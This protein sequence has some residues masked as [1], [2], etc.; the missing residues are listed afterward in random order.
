M[1]P[2]S[3]LTAARFCLA[4]VALAGCFSLVTEPAEAARSIT[5]PPWFVC[6]KY[7]RTISIS[8]PQIWASYGT[9]QVRWVT[10]I[11]RWDRYS[12]QW[13][14]YDTLSFWSSFNYYGQSVTGWTGGN[15]DGITKNIRVS[16]PG[17]Y[18]VKAAVAGT[19]GPLT[20]VGMISGGAYCTMS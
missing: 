14:D 18:R 19:E 3:I 5:P 4:L 20:W 9:E 17:Y 1:K 7:P 2:I 15:Y 6:N 16:H 13:Y 10:R 12:Q 11:H 8:P